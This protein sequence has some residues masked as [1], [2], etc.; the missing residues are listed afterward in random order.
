MENRK[1]APQSK[2]VVGERPAQLADD[3]VRYVRLVRPLSLGDA[4]NDIVSDLV[5][6][7]AAVIGLAAKYGLPGDEILQLVQ[8]VKWMLENGVVR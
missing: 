5:S 7:R 2:P 1:N 8:L 4:P 3:V 6:A